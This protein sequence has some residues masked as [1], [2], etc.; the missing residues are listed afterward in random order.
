MNDDVE[1]IAVSLRSSTKL[2][3]PDA[4]VVASALPTQ[5][6]RIIRAQRL[7]DL[8]WPGLQIVNPAE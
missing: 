2:K 8:G 4:I 5:S 3:L 7:V 1:V 6:T